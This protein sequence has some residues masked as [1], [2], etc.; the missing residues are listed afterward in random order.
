VDIDVVG[1][2]EH[3]VGGVIGGGTDAVMGEG[4]HVLEE[5]VVREVEPG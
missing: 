3:V 1:D 4:L 2:V 5:V